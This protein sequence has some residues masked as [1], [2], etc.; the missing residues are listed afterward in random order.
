MSETRHFVV[1]DGSRHWAKT[2]KWTVKSR[3]IKNLQHAEDELEW[4]QSLDKKNADKYFIVTK[5]VKTKVKPCSSRIVLFIN[6]DK[7]SALYLE[8][9]IK[10]NFNNVLEGSVINGGWKFKCNHSDAQTVVEISDAETA[11]YNEV[12]D[13]AI[14]ALGDKFIWNNQL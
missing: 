7:D 2:V 4:H 5:A 1:K 14:A 13:K 8:H 12:I 6:Y 10:D 11:G 3:G 9:V